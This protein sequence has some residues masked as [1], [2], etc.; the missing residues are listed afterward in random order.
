MPKRR[1]FLAGLSGL[2]TFGLF[3]ERTMAE[4]GVSD[5]TSLTLGPANSA[6][7]R[8]WLVME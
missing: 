3:T 1:E 4:V 7:D 6:D 5:P 2:L 8:P